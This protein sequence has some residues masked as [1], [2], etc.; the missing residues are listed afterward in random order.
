MR[1]FGYFTTIAVI[2]VLFVMLSIQGLQAQADSKKIFPA[3]D[4]PV[5]SG[6]QTQN[7]N[8]IKLYN[9][10][11]WTEAAQAFREAVRAAD[12]S[13]EAHYNLALALDKL[14]Q[15]KEATQEFGHAIKLAPD[16]P[17]ITESEILKA[18]LA[19]KEKN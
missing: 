6:A 2:A 13:A 5:S 1:T 14:Q 19:M 18:H 10:G 7:S 12:E 9:E 4:V 15:H 11:K 3:L 16:N 8:G 17:A